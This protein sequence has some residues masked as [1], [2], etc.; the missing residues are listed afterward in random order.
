MLLIIVRVLFAIVCTGAILT[1]VSTGPEAL[2]PGDLPPG[3]I[4]TNRFWSFI[5]LMVASQFFVLLDVLIPKKRIEV[6]SAIYFGLLVGA[7]LSYLFVL[8]LAPVMT[9]W[10]YREVVVLLTTLTFPYLTISLLLQTKDDFRFVI[11]YVEFSRELKGGRPLVIDSSS[12]IDGRIADVVDT[13]ILDA[14]MVVPQFVLHEIQEIADSSDKSRRTRGRR[15]LEVLAKLQNSPNAEIRMHE[16]D[17]DEFKGM[18]VDHRLVALAKKLG[19]RVM[20]N[21]FN[22]SKVA[23][24]QG[25]ESINLNDDANETA[26]ADGDGTGEPVP[27]YK[28]PSVG[29][30]FPIVT[31]PDS[32]EF[33]GSKFGL[34]WQWHANPQDKWAF[35]FPAKGVLRFNSVQLPDDF[36]NL[37]DLPN[38]LLQKFPAEEFTVTAKVNLSPRFEGEKFGLLIMGLDYSYIGVTNK[39]GKFFV[40]QATAKDADK[41]NAETETAPVELKSREFYLRVKV[42]KYAMCDFSFSADGKNFQKIGEQ[43]KAR[44]GKWIGAKIGLFFTRPAKFNDSG[45]AD[46]DWFRFEK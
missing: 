44:E 42:S 33:N 14:P 21:D 38:L 34:Q 35:M 23:S 20:T 2:I 36:K 39:N 11:P 25:I 37:W 3:L 27:S 24:V 43:F 18:A 1:Y 46:I 19:G 13:K 5:V 22:L 6:V 4:G 45:T 26:D 9:N 15:G 29:G 10:Q 8:A 32:D 7:L 12:L 40:S 30:K 41:G 17:S 28:K 16:T 31:S